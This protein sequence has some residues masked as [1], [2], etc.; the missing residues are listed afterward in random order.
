MNA[1]TFIRKNLKEKLDETLYVAISCDD[2]YCEFAGVVINSVLENTKTHV[3]IHLLCMDVSINHK[4]EFKQMVDLYNAEL[5]FH[6]VDKCNFNGFTTTEYF[7]LAAYSRLLLPSLLPDV[8]KI[9][10]L[11]CDVVVR[12]DISEL[13]DLDINDY[14]VAAALDCIGMIEEK[15]KTHSYDLE[16]YGYINSGVMLINLEYWRKTNC[17][18]LILN[19]LAKHDAPL[20]DQDGINAILYGTIKIIHPKWN[21]MEYYFNLQPAV[22]EEYEDK[23]RVTRKNPYI[24]HFCLRF[25]PWK[26]ECYNWYRYDWL[27]YKNKT[28][29]KRTELTTLDRSFSSAVFYRWRGL[30]RRALYAILW[31]FWHILGKMK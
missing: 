11:D 14:S 29:W 4:K 28:P 3:C 19:W 25:K 17:V 23:V 6:D 20:V 12:H 24:V 9:L 8:K 26:V 13:Y 22:C 1:N 7:S 5:I 2:K 27:K 10:Y 16:K 15:R 18:K 21:F 30:F 31:E